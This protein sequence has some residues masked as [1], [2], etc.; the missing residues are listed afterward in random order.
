VR[1]GVA[2]VPLNVRSEHRPCISQPSPTRPANKG[3]KKKKDISFYIDHIFISD[4]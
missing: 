3:K 2:R 4:I 1:V